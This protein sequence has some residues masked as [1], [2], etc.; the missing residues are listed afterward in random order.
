MA[1][2]IAYFWNGSYGM[3]WHNLSNPVWEELKN[4]LKNLGKHSSS[5]KKNLL[6]D[7][8][9]RVESQI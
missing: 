7:L 4:H 6:E 5:L 1:W 8:N 2:Q 9:D 3:K